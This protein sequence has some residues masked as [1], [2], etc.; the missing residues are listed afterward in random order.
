[1]NEMPRGLMVIMF[2]LAIGFCGDAAALYS[3]GSATVIAI[4]IV[5]IL[6]KVAAIWGML[7]RTQTGWIVAVSVFAVIVILNA[8]AVSGSQAPVVLLRLLIPVGCLVYLIMIKNE[9]DQ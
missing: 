4:V 6:A 7:M 2:L 5:L 9:F 3:G 1:M 8:L